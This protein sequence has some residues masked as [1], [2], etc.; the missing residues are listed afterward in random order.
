LLTVLPLYLLRAVVENVVLLLLAAD[1]VLPAK[2]PFPFRI[3]DRVFLNILPKTI[4]ATNVTP[5][6]TPFAAK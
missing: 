5:I 1:R 4:D 3:E 6:T 2:P